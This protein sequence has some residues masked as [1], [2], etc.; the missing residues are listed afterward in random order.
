MPFYQ[1]FAEGW[2]FQIFSSLFVAESHFGL[3]FSNGFET[4][5]LRHFE[6]LNLSEPPFKAAEKAAE[7]AR[8]VAKAT[9]VTWWPWERFSRPKSCWGKR[10]FL[11]EWGGSHNQ[12]M[13]SGN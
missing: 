4:T 11:L 8:Q 6:T 9:G 13:G 5:F 12:S 10:S 2:W 7:E 1:N 3:Y